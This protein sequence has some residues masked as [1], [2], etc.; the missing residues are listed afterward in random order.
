MTPTERLQV[1]LGERSYEI[2][3]GEGLLGRAG[4]FLAPILRSPRV[5]VVTDETVAALHL[6]ELLRALETAEIEAQSFV[7]PAGEATKSFDR[8]SELVERL[9][10]AKI[11]RNST[12]VAFGGGVIG[13]LAGFAAAITLRG[14]D[15]VQIP[16]TLLS[17]VDSSVGG[18]TGINSGHGKNL[19]GAFHQPRL[20][21]ADSGVL[22]TLP[23]RQMLAGYAEIAKIGLIEDPDFFTWLEGHGTAVVEGEHEP[24]RHAVMQACAA[25]A[26]VV[27]ADEREVGRRAL[28][29]LWPHLRPRL[30][31]R[32]RLRR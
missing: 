20:V 11:E 25:K 8:L 30:G 28:L 15:F 3:V 29:N 13:D 4:E 1:A 14:I 10:S 23:R 32:G 19:V 21:L 26:R 17:Q 22:E 18:K 31:G 27:A 9:L 7:V 12:L 6:E 2:L 24:L 16:T 5:I